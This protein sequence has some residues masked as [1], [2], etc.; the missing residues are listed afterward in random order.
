[1]KLP[2]WKQRHNSL[3]GASGRLPLFNEAI[4]QVL[5]GIDS[6]GGADVYVDLWL[7]Q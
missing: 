5:T 1:M 4:H 2:C 3:D 6:L 7:M